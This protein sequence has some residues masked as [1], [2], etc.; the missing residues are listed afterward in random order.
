VKFKVGDKVLVTA[1]KDKGKTS[2]ITAVLPQA[3]KVVVK[4]ANM[5][6]RHVKPVQGRSGEKVRKE[7]A[8]D[9]AKIAIINDKGNPDRIGFRVA[10]DGSK[11]RIF[12]KTGKVVPDNKPKTDTKG[13]K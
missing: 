4:D 2:E 3:N 7:R 5:Y 12:K 6:T 8:L 13:K 1:G 9:T 11:D 10:K